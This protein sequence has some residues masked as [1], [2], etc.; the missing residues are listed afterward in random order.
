M[1]RGVT[2]HE[3]GHAFHL[4]NSFDCPLGSTVMYHVASDLSVITDC[5]IAAV[6][7]RYAPS[8]TPT[9]TPAGGGGG[10]GEPQPGNRYC[11][12][13]YEATDWE[14]YDNEYMTWN[15]AFTTYEWT[16]SCDLHHRPEGIEDNE[17]FPGS[18]D[19]FRAISNEWRVLEMDQPEWRQNLPLQSQVNQSRLVAVGEPVRNASRRSP[20]GQRITTDYDVRLIDV[21]KGIAV[22]GSMISV[23][24]PG[25]WVTE[26]DGVILDARARRVRKMENGKRYMM[27]LRN[28]ADSDDA[29]IPLRGSQGLY[30]LPRNGSRVRH[31]GRSFDLPPADDGELVSLFLQQIRDLSRNR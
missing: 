23:K 25:G 11:S 4:D 14:Y 9:P 31:L 21:F 18:V 13:G 10:G 7:S 15:Y 16:V 24:M 28:A 1:T 6:R 22:A 26:D 19:S 27:F 29:F 30:E 17:K 20:D 12:G 5:D 2:R 8:P 3:I